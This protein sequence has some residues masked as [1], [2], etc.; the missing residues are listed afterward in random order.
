MQAAIAHWGTDSLSPVPCALI[1]VG[2]PS[3]VSLDV[4]RHEKRMG[5]SAAG[6]GR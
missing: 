5:R 2:R 3:I 1:P 4:D 6:A